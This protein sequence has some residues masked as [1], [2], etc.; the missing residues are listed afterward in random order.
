MG[1]VFGF[2]I[3]GLVAG[4][5]AERLTESNHGLFTNLIVGLIGAFAAVAT[6]APSEK[7]ALLSL[8]ISEAMSCTATG[9]LIAMPM[10]TIGAIIPSSNQRRR[11][12]V[13]PSASRYVRT[14]ASEASSRMGTNT[15]GTSAMR[16]IS[17]EDGS[18]S[19]GTTRR[20][21]AT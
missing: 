17:S 5:I 18:C 19:N 3:I 10:L 21:P 7:S 9:L 15:P 1:G 13:G 2:I 14:S 8:S 16:Q 20:F 6:A 11:A 4:Y 12:R